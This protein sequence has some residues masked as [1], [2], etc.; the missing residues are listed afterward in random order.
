MISDSPTPFV[1][2]VEPGLLVPE[3]RLAVS[4]PR[5]E[6]RLMERPDDFENDFIELHLF[7]VGQPD[8]SSP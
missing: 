1:L 6:H 5:L 4:S 3:E 7:R 8:P 2:D